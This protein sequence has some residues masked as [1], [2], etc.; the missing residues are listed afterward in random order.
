VKG[1]VEVISGYAGGKADNPNYESLE[2]NNNGHAETVEIYYD[3]TLIDYP[4]LLNIYFAGQDPTQVNGQGND[5]GTQYRSIIFFR[6]STEADLATAKMSSM[7]EKYTSPL[8]VQLVPFTRFWVAEKIH[9]NY[10]TNNPYGNYVQNVSIPE[11]KLV[12]QEY[13]NLIK[14]DHFY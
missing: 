7:R 11:I 8:T 12:Q 10:I 1:V 3:T 14:P 4:T 13:P 5:R 6:N 2:S 9:Q